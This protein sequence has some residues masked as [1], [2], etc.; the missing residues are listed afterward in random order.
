MNSNVKS[1]SD[2]IATNRSVAKAVL[3]I[4]VI[5]AELANKKLRPTKGLTRSN[6]ISY[7]VN[8]V[9]QKCGS[10]GKF[11]KYLNLRQLPADGFLSL[12]E[13]KSL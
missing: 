4:H 8:T 2:L 3:A 1:D 12:T 13:N 11:R 6:V 10:G 5:I 7:S 9:I